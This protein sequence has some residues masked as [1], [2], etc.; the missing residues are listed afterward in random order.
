[1]KL[2]QIVS[3][4]ACVAFIASCGGGGS[5]RVAGKQCPAN[6]VPFTMNL[7]AN[8]ASVPL[9]NLASELAGGEYEYQSSTL[10]YVNKSTNFRVEVTDA[11]DKRTGKLVAKTSCVRNAN[12]G[13]DIDFSVEGIGRLVVQKV[14]PLELFEMSNSL[15]DQSIS[16]VRRFGFVVRHGKIEPVVSATDKKFESPKDVY[17]DV[18]EKFQILFIKKNANDYEIRSID[19]NDAE[20]YFLSIRLRWKDPATKN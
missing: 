17:Q 6:Y 7:A 19:E 16:D 5:R 11:P 4:V 13:L 10:Y 3:G 15:K 1:M 2:F 18:S 20:K 9:E 12:G 14:N 8:E